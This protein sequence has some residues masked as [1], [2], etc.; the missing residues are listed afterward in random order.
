MK[1]DDKYIKFFSNNP[2]KKDESIRVFTKR[3]S[4]LE[5]CPVNSPRSLEKPYK[6]YRALVAGEELGKKDVATISEE[7]EGFKIKSKWQNAKGEWLYS[8]VKDTD[9]D[10]LKELK[11]FKED[12]LN[13][14]PKSYSWTVPKVSS[15]KPTIALEICTPDLHFG[16]GDVKDL[17]NKAMESTVQLVTQALAVYNIEK[18]ILPIG[19]DG[20]NSEGMSMATTK[21]TPQEESVPWY[22]S[23]KSY[24]NF[25]V[26]QID[27][28]SIIA[29]VEVLVIPGNH[30]R[31]RMV[32][33][34][35]V[36]TARYENNVNVEID[37]E[38][39]PRKYVKYGK[40]LIGFDHGDIIKGKDLPLIM[41]TEK[42]SEWADSEFREWH[43]GHYHKEMIDEFRGVKV[44]YLPS[45]SVMD[46]YHL[47]NGYEQMKCSQ[48]FVWDKNK[49]LKS[50]L[51]YNL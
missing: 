43:L 35:E 22:E 4:K 16:K 11:A 50:I 2:I 25:L 30:D 28:L 5:G 40:V 49:G 7:H 42:P 32:Y 10:L 29:P 17:H 41:A 18:I 19:N 34:G 46:T 48:A 45:I 12:F 24:W 15:D 20:L 13:S 37:N 21:G 9:E 27:Y 33:I 14:I 1:L 51:Q 38:V 6:K 36:L 47:Q 8:Y 39:H 26:Q 23:F 44:R 31:E 3:L